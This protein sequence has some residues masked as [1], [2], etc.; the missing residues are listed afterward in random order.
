MISSLDMSIKLAQKINKKGGTAYYVGGYIRDKLIDENSISEEH[1]IDIEVHDIDYDILEGII[2]K[3]GTDLNYGKSFGITSLAGYNIDIAMPRLETNTGE[4][5]TDFEVLVDKN[6]GTY[7]ASKRRDFTINSI[8]QNIITGEIIDHFAGR[9]DIKNRIIRHIDDEKF[10]E[11]PLRVLRACQFSSRFNF[12]IAESTKDLCRTIDI[13]KLSKE[14]IMIELEKALLLSEKPSIF[15]NELDS[16]GHL[17]FWFKEIKELQNIE[18]SSIHH[19]EG[20]VYNH[21]MMVIDAAVKYRDKASNPLYFILAALCHDLGKIEATTNVYGKI[22]SLQ[23]E[24]IGMDIAERFLKRLSSEKR[25]IKY[26]KN[27]VKLHMKPNMYFRDNSKIKSTNMMF[28]KSIEPIDLIYLAQAD[29]EGKISEYE[30]KSSKEFLLERLEIYNNLMKEDYIDGNDLIKKGVEV[31]D[32]FS[33]IIDFITKLRMAQ[34]GKDTALKE[35]IRYANQ[36]NE[37]S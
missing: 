13:T 14:R 32:N 4:G 20:N 12:N 36:I 34:V 15:F 29:N 9:E 6:I 33:K 37:R 16:M 21:T 35:A 1:D 10:V 17:D 25:L 8:M 19:K 27:M 28:H 30:T 23:H 7:K 18:Q 11:D 22:R 24:I 26:V 31:N 3:Y 2:N 5:H